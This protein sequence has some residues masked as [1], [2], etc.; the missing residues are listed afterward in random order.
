MDWTGIAQTE[1]SYSFK[2]QHYIAAC[3]IFYL[4]IALNLSIYKIILM[5]SF[6]YSVNSQT[7]Q[8][9]PD[10]SVLL[11][12]KGYIEDKMTLRA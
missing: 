5:L 9:H 11:W 12:G 8:G 6:L 1:T 2:I 7:V 4:K 3:L 10:F